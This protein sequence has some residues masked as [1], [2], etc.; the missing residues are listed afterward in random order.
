MITIAPSG[1]VPPRFLA[2]R[3]ASHWTPGVQYYATPPAATGLTGGGRRTRPRLAPPTRPPD[4]RSPPMIR[5]TVVFRLRHDAGS[6]AEADFLAQRA[7][8]ADAD[9]RR[10]ALRGAAP[11]GDA[12]RL[13]PSRSRWSSPTRRRT[14]PT[15]STPRTRGSFRDAGSRR[16]RSSSSSTSRR[17]PEQSRRDAAVLGRDRRHAARAA[18]ADRGGARGPDPRE[19]RAPQSRRQR[20]GP[21]RARDRARRR[22]PRRPGARA[23]RSSRRRRATPAS[24][25]RSSRACAATGSCA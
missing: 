24:A 23:T 18:R 1:T 15:T 10:R 16:S 7:R 8:A 19:V 2:G 9:P 20:Q 22:A 17:T 14:R 4:P 21:H 25:S 5:H 13:P 12:E 11:D 3:G 6:A